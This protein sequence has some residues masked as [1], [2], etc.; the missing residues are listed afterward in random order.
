ML[1]QSAGFYG[2]WRVKCETCEKGAAWT[3]W[4]STSFGSSHSFRLSRSV[5]LRECYPLIS[6]MKAIEGLLYEIVFA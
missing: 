4:L 2:P 5:I 1:K 6:N 3:D